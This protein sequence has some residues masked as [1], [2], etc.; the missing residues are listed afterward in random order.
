MINDR[1]F[2]LEFVDNIRLNK[3]YYEEDNDITNISLSSSQFS[4][5]KILINVTTFITIN[6]IE[7]FIVIK[8][9][10]SSLSFQTYINVIIIIYSYRKKLHQVC[11]DI[12][13]KSILINENVKA[14]AKVV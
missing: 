2:Y 5:N 1:V 12:E 14:Q 13:T 6:K 10:K 4:L 8:A 3:H 11:I 7:I 9:E